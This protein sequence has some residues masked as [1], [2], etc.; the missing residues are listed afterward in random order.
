MNF[1]NR[2]PS[3][4]ISYGLYLYFSGLSLRRASERH[5]SCQAKPS[6][7]MELDTKVQVPKDFNKEIKDFRIC[8]R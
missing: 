3:E 4:Y 2:T 8:Y 7:N 6:I 5:F 1:R